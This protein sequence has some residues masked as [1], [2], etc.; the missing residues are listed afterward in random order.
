MSVFT[1]IVYVDSIACMQD[2]IWNTIDLCKQLIVSPSCSTKNKTQK[3]VHRK[4]SSNQLKQRI[5]R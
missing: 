1:P 5:W 4:S 2:M 3:A